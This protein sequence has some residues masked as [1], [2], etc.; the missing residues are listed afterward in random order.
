MANA[1]RMTVH[2]A[3]GVVLLAA[4]LDEPHNIT[5]PA[6]KAW[7]AWQD[8]NGAKMVEVVTKAQRDLFDACNYAF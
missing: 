4:Y 2:A 6:A 7:I 5:S 1:S 3:R 8:A